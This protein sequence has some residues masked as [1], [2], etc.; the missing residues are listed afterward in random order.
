[1]AFEAFFSDL[2][3]EIREWVLRGVVLLVAFGLIW[4]LRKALTAAVIAPLRA[5]ANRTATTLDDKILDAAIAPLRGVIVVIAINIATAI[6]VPSDAWL[7]NVVTIAGRIVIVGAVLLFI[8]RLIDLTLPSSRYIFSVTGVVIEE[9]LLP[10]VRVAL[11][12]LFASIVV[13]IVIQELGYDISALLAGL[14]LGG[15]GVSLAAK[16]TLANFFGFI[17]I[18]GDRPCDVGDYIRTQYGEGLVEHVGVRSTR[19]RQLDQALIYVP[20]NLLANTQ[21]LNWSRLQKRRLDFILGVT[22]STT[23]EEMTVLLDRLRQMLRERPTVQ[24]D[25]VV[26]YFVDFGDS[27]LNV[28][29]RAFI[30]IADWGEFH[31]EK[32]RINLEIMRIIREL[33]LSVAFPSRSLYLEALNMPEPMSEAMKA[34]AQRNTRPRRTRPSAPPPADDYQPDMPHGDDYDHNT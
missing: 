16:D 34:V 33:G 28:L 22:Y 2:P 1:M 32:E 9:R 6:I 8:Y 11:K 30:K 18:V 29:I 14:G 23:A 25:S 19:I 15:L 4:V 26:V 12:V 10:F 27:S 24:E 17:S 21:I 13:V 20:N 31:A 7:A 5:L 3:Q